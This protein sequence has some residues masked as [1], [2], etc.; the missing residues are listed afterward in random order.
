L[1]AASANR[2][3][4]LVM[5]DEQ[6]I[7]TLAV[8]MLKYLGHDAEAASDGTAA[9]E[10]YQRALGSGHSFDAVILD[11]IVPGGMGG[12]ETIERLAEID[13]SV[14]GIVVSGYAQDP[15]VT[16]YREH[17]FKGVI[18]K[19]FTLQELRSTLDA[20][21]LTPGVRTVH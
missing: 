13:P 18:G 16:R 7:R 3:R 5:D 9:V 11:L 20:L 19:P 8:N 6:S 4:I 15:V 21:M 1:S 10:Q 17:G 14:T 12:R 2:A